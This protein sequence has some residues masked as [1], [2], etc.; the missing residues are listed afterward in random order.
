MFHSIKGCYKLYS[1]RRLKKNNIQ[2]DKKKISATKNFFLKAKKYAQQ[3][4]IKV[5]INSIVNIVM[6]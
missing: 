1:N 5:K 4:I 2:I 3:I 6:A